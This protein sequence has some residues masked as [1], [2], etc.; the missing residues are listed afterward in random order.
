MYAKIFREKRCE[1][2][3]QLRQKSQG[4]ACGGPRDYLGLQL[5][6]NITRLGYQHWICYHSVMKLV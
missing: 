5:I 3:T 1:N 4:L 6:T 2:I